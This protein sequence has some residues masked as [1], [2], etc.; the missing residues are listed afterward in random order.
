MT[1]VLKIG[2]SLIKEAPQ[3]IER[4]IEEFGSEGCPNNFLAKNLLEPANKNQAPLISSITPVSILIVPGGGVFADAV[5]TV[6]EK[7]S[8][9]PDAAHW[10]AILGMEQYA[11]YL[12]DKSKLVSSVDTV[13]NLPRG[14]SILFPYKLLKARDPLPHT[15]AVSAD[16]IAAWVAKETG[17][18]LIK[19][20]DV[21]GIYREGKLVREVSVID[22]TENIKEG[23][24]EEGVEGDS[25]SCIDSALPS[26][27]LESQ[28]DCLI[29]NGKYP[30]RV[31]QAIYG[32]PVPGTKVKGNI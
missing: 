7:F 22:I 16:T 1:I 12:Q 13:E 27:L 19:V 4:L 6:D 15:W 9:S 25:K 30:E 5:R 24:I 32:K 20:T 21:D 17:A 23:N 26:F 28:M 11:C 14:V 2:G 31:I 3:L 10:M 18:S 29:V 8:L